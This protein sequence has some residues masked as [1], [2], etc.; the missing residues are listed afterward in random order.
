MDCRNLC[1]GTETGQYASIH[2]FNLERESVTYAGSIESIVIPLLEATNSLLINRPVGC[3][4]FTPFGAVNS[5]DR[6]AILEL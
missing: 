2:V 4:Y 1:F 3:V 5:I 6:A